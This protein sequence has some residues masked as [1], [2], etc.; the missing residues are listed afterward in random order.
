MEGKIYKKLI[1]EMIITSFLGLIIGLLSL[2]ICIISPF[3][4]I[5]IVL[6]GAILT[7][8]S[9]SILSYIYLQKAYKDLKQN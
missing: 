1:W 3:S 7:I 8:G 4:K 2:L 6:A 5:L 9:V